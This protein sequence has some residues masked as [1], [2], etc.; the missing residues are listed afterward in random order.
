[1]PCYTNV[2]FVSD[3]YAYI[4]RP[5]SGLHVIDISNPAS[6]TLLAGNYDDDGNKSVHAQGVCVSTGPGGRT[7]SPGG[8]GKYAYVLTS[9]VLEIIDI[10]NPTSPTIISWFF[11]MPWYPTDVFISGRY[12]YITGSRNEGE[13]LQIIDVSNPASPTTVSYFTDPCDEDKRGYYEFTGVFVSGKYAYVADD[14]AGLRIIDISKPASPTLVSSCTFIID[15]AGE[16]ERYLKEGNYAKAVESFLKALKDNPDDADVWYNLACVCS[17]MGKVDE[18]L[19]ALKKAIQYGW[20]DFHW[21]DND[22][23]LATLRQDPRYKEISK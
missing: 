9:R 2:L 4:L 20:S 1:T 5:I 13:C 6:P 12:A 10:S 15:Y 3:N 7:C 8:S 11:D 23:D 21:M 22:P 18:G 14:K 19:G 16:G 17:L